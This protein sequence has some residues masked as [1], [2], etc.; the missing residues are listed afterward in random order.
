MN[1]QETYGGTM[2]NTA[3]GKC[4]YCYTVFDK[5]NSMY[6]SGVK[7]NAKSS[8]ACIG[9]T[10]FTSSSVTEFKN[11]FKNNP[12]EFEI[13]FEYFDNAKEAFDA[14][15]AFHL[16]HNVGKN[17][18]FYN[19]LTLHN[20]Y[21][22]A[23]TVLC[24][25][26]GGE[27]YRV[28]CQEF[29]LKTHKSVSSNKMNVYILPNLTKL[30][31]I[32]CDM[33][34]PVLHQTQ[35]SGYVLCFDN[36]MEK[37]RRI[38]K[39]EFISNPNRFSGITK[40][41]ITV[42]STDTGK[43]VELKS[44]EYQANKELYFINTRNKTVAVF[45]SLENKMRH[46][47]Y[48]EMQNNK[49]RYKHYNYFNRVVY[50]IQTRKNRSIP[51]QDFESERNRYILRPNKHSQ[52]YKFDNIIYTSFKALVEMFKNKYNKNYKWTSPATIAKKEKL[53]FMT[54]KE[55]ADG[56]DFPI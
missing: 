53:E 19:V 49:D 11:R 6:Y 13:Y 43:K 26:D 23:G 44:T 47:P 15:R 9:K 28:S 25:D 18:L 41:K 12:E 50:D 56:K 22:G 35:F 52:I 46:V 36:V 24:I 27:T 3:D 2:N 55:H 16:K 54:M 38:P 21:C 51:I 48:E 40:N 34:D 5:N 42:V 32:P 31:N 37:N 17:K 10:Y 20:T 14:E 33:F 1:L 8:V 4:F 7:T 45:D 29:A 30:I 39:E